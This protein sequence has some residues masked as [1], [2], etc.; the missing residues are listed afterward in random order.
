MAHTDKDEEQPTDFSP[1]AE[2]HMLVAAGEYHPYA[3]CVLYKQLR[4]ADKVKSCLNSIIEYARSADLSRAAVTEDPTQGPEQ[5]AGQW[6]T[7]AKQL[8]V[9]AGGE[10]HD[11]NRAAKIATADALWACAGDLRRADRRAG[12]GT[13][14]ML[15]AIGILQEKYPRERIEISIEPDGYTYTTRVNGEGKNRPVNDGAT[16]GDAF[17]IC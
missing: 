16:I 3:A 13:D 14:A 15:N 9:S 6:E 2:C 10:P 17:G 7:R 4:Q 1:C 12:V 8:Q 5:L 11:V